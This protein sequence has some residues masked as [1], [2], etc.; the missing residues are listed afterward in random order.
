MAGGGRTWPVRA[1]GLFLSVCGGFVILFQ[2][3]RLL[4]VTPMGCVQCDMTQTVEKAVMELGH[5]EMV[6]DIYDLC[7]YVRRCMNSAFS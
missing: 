1:S 2:G 6:H 7:V 3:T 4:A 5:T